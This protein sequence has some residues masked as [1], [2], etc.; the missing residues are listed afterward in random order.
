MEYNDKVLEHFYSPRNIGKIENP[1]GSA[2]IGDP[3]CGDFIT[4]NIKVE[5]DEI[6]DFKYKVFGCAAAIATT[7]VVSEM[8]KGKRIS[9]ASKYTDD[10]VVAFLG[11]LPEGKQHCSLLGIMGL[12][13]ALTDLQKS[14][15]QIKRL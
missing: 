13:A 11:G 10:D 2:I 9:D 4:V 7:S 15:T 6:I 3:N 14:R 1:D 12:H 8:V 5:G